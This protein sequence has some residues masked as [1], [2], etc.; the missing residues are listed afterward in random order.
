MCLSLPAVM[1]EPG[2]DPRHG[3]D[4]QGAGKAVPSLCILTALI[5]LLPDNTPRLRFQAHGFLL[6]TRSKSVSGTVP[7]D[8]PSPNDPPHSKN[9]TPIWYDEASGAPRF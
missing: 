9:W 7:W 4:I 8:L 2:G 5:H 6:Y 1:Q 3:A